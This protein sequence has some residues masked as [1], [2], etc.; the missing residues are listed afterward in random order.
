MS[1]RIHNVHRHY[2]SVGPVG[3]TVCVLVSDVITVRHGRMVHSETRTHHASVS[4][5]DDVTHAHTFT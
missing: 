2:N 4:H 1:F 5:C 3:T